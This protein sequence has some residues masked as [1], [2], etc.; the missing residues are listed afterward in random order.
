MNIAILFIGNPNGYGAAVNRVLLYQKGLIQN[1]CKVELI[2]NYRKK[3]SRLGRLWWSSVSSF[4]FFIKIFQLKSDC[5]IVFAYVKGWHAYF[6]VWLATRLT[7]KKFIAEVNEKPGAPYGNKLTEIKFVKWF[8]VWFF[9]HFSAYLP[10]AY[11]AI[12]SYLKQ[13]LSQFINEKNIQVVPIIVDPNN[14]QFAFKQHN[15][16]K[17]FIF[18]SGALSDRKDGIVGVFEAFAIANKK[19]NGGLYFYLTDRIAPKNVKEEISKIIENNNLSEK[20][21]FLGLVP[22]DTLAAYQKECSML[23]LNKPD[24]DQNKYNFSTKLGEYLALGKPVIFTPVGEMAF[25]L[26]DKQ[27]AFEVPVNNSEKMAETIL[28]IIN[29]EPIVGVIAQNGKKLAN[30]TFNY[31]YQTDNLRLFFQ[32]FSS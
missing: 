13:Y 14:Q 26:H 32:Q 10:D 28:T 22:Q 24:T 25:Y 16:N 8:N 27:N 9:E 20:V 31:L 5:K 21:R 1:G 18:H 6:F 15:M 30:S 29:N 3:K 7:K 19:L 12:S 17:P 11:I 2:S 4:V 23:I